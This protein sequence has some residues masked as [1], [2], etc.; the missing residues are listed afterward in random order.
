L[1]LAGAIE[2]DTKDG[3]QTWRNSITIPLDEMGIYVGDPVKTEPVATGMDVMEAQNKFNG[4]IQSGN[5]D[6]FEKMFTRIVQKDIRLVNR[7]DFLIVHLFPDIP[8][9]GTIHE[10]ALAWMQKKP[11]YLIWKDAKS[12]LSKWALYLVI[13]SGGRLFD[14]EN[15]LTEFIRVKYN[16]KN[17]SF[18]V[19]F[20]QII[21]AI[22]RLIEENL[23]N[24][25][26]NSNGNQEKIKQDL[27]KKE[28]KK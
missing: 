11:I 2:F 10:M 23:Y 22:S 16:L 18:R 5:Y 24:L 19:Q 7:A 20:I 6:I 28:E 14:S 9:T 8:T 4:W 25:K 13:S 3:G 1:K 21:K 12:K 15:K 17:Q 27:E 26:T